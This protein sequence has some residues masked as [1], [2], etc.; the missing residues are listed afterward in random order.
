MLRVGLGLVWDGKGKFVVGLSL[1]KVGF[2][3]GL[4]GFRV[5]L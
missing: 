4:G 2:E 5:G 1:F 3:R